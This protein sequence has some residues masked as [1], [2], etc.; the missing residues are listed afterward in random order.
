M[1]H[2]TISKTLPLLLCFCVTAKALQLFFSCAILGL[3]NFCEA[4]TLFLNMPHSCFSPLR[5]L[6]L[7][8]FDQEIEH[9]SFLDTDEQTYLPSYLPET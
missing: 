1:F 4:K 5:L 7:S 6:V 9:I 3:G 2:C 8:D